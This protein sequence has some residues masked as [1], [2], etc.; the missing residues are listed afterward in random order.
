[1][2][3]RVTLLFAIA[4]AIYSGS[5][6]HAQYPSDLGLVDPGLTDYEEIYIEQRRQYW[7]ELGVGVSGAANSVAD[8][9]RLAQVAIRRQYWLQRG[10]S[11]TDYAHNQSD[12][13]RI[14]NVIIRKNEWRRRGISVN[15]FAYD[16]NQVD[17]MGQAAA[18]RRQSAV[19]PEHFAIPAV[20][21]NAAD[22]QSISNPLNAASTLQPTNK[23]Q[24]MNSFDKRA[25]IG[26]YDSAKSAKNF[27]NF[28]YRPSVG[29]HQVRSYIRSDGT[30]VPNHR[31]T[32]ADSSFWNNWSSMGN[33]NPYTGRVGGRIPPSGGE[34]QNVPGY[35]RP[36]G[37]HVPGQYRNN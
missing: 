36:N 14:A 25:V 35:L 3:L 6:L 16:V 17:L 22:H 23:S 7:A 4:T 9:D 11:V 29:D 30:Y 10:I 20:R 1:M 18:Q 21:G 27:Y 15:G 12:V 34:A 19:K 8:V 37:L 2:D 33:V 28:N 24:T 5:Q 31:R 13:D 32:D 26:G